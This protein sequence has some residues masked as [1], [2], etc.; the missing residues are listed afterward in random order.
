MSENEPTSKVCTKCHTNKLLE[1]FN[2][3]KKGRYGKHAQCRICTNEINRL[4]Y[5]EN[6]EIKEK[7]KQWKAANPDKVKMYV[8]KYRDNHPEVKE[9]SLLKLK[10]WT[11]ANPDKVKESNK[12]HYED[13]R[14]KIA[15]DRQ[16]AYYNTSQQFREYEKEHCKKD[17]SYLPHNNTCAC[18]GKFTN[19]SILPHYKTKKHQKWHE[20]NPTIVWPPQIGG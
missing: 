7:T 16:R 10:A 5:L 14:E 12:K 17:Y 19:Q 20:A 8:K 2:I 9:K 6:P 18:G 3:R 15:E 1:E 4:V 13:N 11:A